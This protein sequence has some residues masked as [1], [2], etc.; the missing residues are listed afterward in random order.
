MACEAKAIRAHSV[1]NA[2]ALDL[3]SRDGHVTGLTKR[4]DKERGPQISFDAI[5]RNQAT[6][7]TGLCAKHDAD[8]FRPLDTAPFDPTDRQ[9]LFLA[10]YRS[11]M[12]EL[13][14]VMEAVPQ[15]Q[16]VYKKRVELGLDPKEQ[17][18][19]AGMFAVEYMMKA[20]LAYIYKTAFDEIL[21]NGTYADCEHDLL[22]FKNQRPT[23]A[24]S[25]LFGLGHLPTGEDWLRIALNVVPVSETETA[26]VFSYRA[27]DAPHARTRLQRILGAEGDYQKY[28]LSKLILNNCENF[29][30]APNY[31]DQWNP[32]KRN[33]VTQ[34]FIQTMFEDGLENESEHFYLF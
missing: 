11:L 13:H 34:F 15:L 33:A 31:I 5:G 2:R 9:H 10:A 12:R 8:I 14:A 18:S 4:I 22:W 26:A 17:P 19:P 32:E 28:E 7:F 16:G 6:T 30:L 24:V 23:I 25:S 21:A 3:L 29:V 27:N 1:Q 20:Y